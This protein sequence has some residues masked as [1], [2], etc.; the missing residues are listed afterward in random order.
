MFRIVAQTGLVGDLEYSNDLER[1]VQDTCQSLLSSKT[2][3]IF[4]GASLLAIWGR[5]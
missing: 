4:K 5:A 2:A 1:G 3:M